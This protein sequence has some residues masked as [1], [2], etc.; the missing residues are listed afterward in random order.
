[1]N[2]LIA[3]TC[4]DVSGIGP[5]VIT[6]ALN[7]PAIK[8]S[9]F[10]YLMIGPENILKKELK[11]NT[12]ID[13]NTVKTISTFND[14]KINT[15]FTILDAT[16][17][18]LIHIEKGKLSTISGKW[19]FSFVDT[20]V[21]LALNKK[22]SAIVTAPINKDAWAKA[23]IQEKGH[24]EFL[25][26]K[27]NAN[28]FA[29]AFYTEDLKVILVTTHLPINKISTNLST[30][31]ILDKIVLADA[32][33]KQLGKQKPTIGVCGLNPHAGEEELLGDEEK[34]F[35]SPAIL[36]AQKLG[37]NALGPYPADTIF[38]KSF[39]DKNIDMIVS[40][41]HDQALAPLKL[42]HFH[43]AVNITLGLPF[44]RTSPDHGT[45][46]DIAT[47]NIANHN[48]MKNAIL[49]AMKLSSNG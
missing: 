39:H 41:Y 26:K 11:S 38:Y 18:E 45:A 19:A 23:G 29:M 42:I 21:D 33:L 6:K 37:I 3:I 46:F 35:I 43:D 5:E 7:E 10:N 40:M 14:Y 22:V 32:F 25:A 36:Q 27:S 28:K 1:M 20:A 48:S 44:I 49:L 13:I 16:N 2:N 47:K 31:I 15:K 24:T 12:T 8:D 4:G 30:D 9:S 34:K 17:N